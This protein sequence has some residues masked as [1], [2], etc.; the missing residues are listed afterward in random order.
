VFFSRFSVNRRLTELDLKFEKLQKE[1]ERLLREFSQLV[2][3]WDATASRVT[4]VLRRIRTTEEAQERR[5]E[6]IEAS[7]PI[8]LAPTP[9]TAT[10][11]M[12][13]IRA[14]LAQRKEGSDGVLRR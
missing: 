12:E 9:G 5:S 11:R 2:Q 3:E 10:G 14:Q 13:K 4:K 1:N 7:E 6:G 8:E